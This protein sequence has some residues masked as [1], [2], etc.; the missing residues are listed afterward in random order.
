[1]DNQEEKK[2]RGGKREGAGRKK[3]TF[4]KFGFNAT[5]EVAEILEKIPNKT[6]Y[7]LQ[8]ILEKNK[9]EKGRF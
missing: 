9:R 4:K 2:K 5:E 1:M 3:T 6:E 7:I 8:A